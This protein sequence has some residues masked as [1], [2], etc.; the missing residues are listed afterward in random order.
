[1]TDKQQ[2]IIDLHIQKIIN[3][4]S[5]LFQDVLFSGATADMDRDQIYC[6]M[7]FNSIQFST[8]LATKI[9]LDFLENQDLISFKSDEHFLQKLAFKMRTDISE[10]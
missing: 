4:N 10:S 5:H 2:E 3:D 1:M 9:I 8:S 7:M 6:K